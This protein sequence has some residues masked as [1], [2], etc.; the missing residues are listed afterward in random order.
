MCNNII[1]ETATEEQ[2]KGIENNKILA[3]SEYETEL[4]LIDKASSKSALNNIMNELKKKYKGTLPQE[5]LNAINNKGSSLK[6]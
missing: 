6:M 1:T 4:K 2:Q 5:L 3:T